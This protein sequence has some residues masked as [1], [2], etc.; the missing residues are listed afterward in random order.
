MYESPFAQ[1]LNRDYW[2]PVR[3][4]IIA[5]MQLCAKRPSFNRGDVI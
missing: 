5:L 1:M 4:N 3:L 2:R